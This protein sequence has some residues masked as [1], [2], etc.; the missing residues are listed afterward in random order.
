[1]K[2]TTTI[3]LAALTLSVFA[4]AACSTVKPDEALHVPVPQQ[5]RAAAAPEQMPAADGV[6][7]QLDRGA[8]PVP[9]WWKAY[10]SEELDA[11][12]EEGLAHSP[13][14]AAAQST[15]KSAHEA[16]RAQLGETLMPSVDLQGGAIREKALGLPVL[17]KE[18]FDYNV[19]DAQ[20]TA[21]YTFN[22]FGAQVLADRSAQRRYQEQ[23]YQLEETRRALA[24]NI[25]LATINAASM[26][27]QLAA[28][29]RLVDLAEERARQTKERFEAGSASRADML[30]DEQQAASLAATLPPM[31]AQLQT[32][33]HAQAILLGRTPDR[34]PQPLAMDALHLPQHVP[35]ALP[36]DLLHQRPDILA[37]EA[38]VRAS[39]DAAGAAKAELFPSLTLSAGY[40]RGG[41]DW[42]TFT[43][44]AGAIWSA[45]SMITQPLFHG[46][47]LRA[48]KREYEAAYE[49]S[50]SQYEQTVLTAFANV[51]D[52]LAALEE[53]A[54]ALAQSE[55]AQR[56]AQA[57]QEDSADRYHLGSVPY[58]GTLT[59]GERLQTAN[60]ELTRARALRLADTAN[61]FQAM[62]DAPRGSD[63]NFP[64]TLPTL[65]GS[66]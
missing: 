21:S 7:Q 50:V 55:R 35:V 58:W 62:G 51:A 20:A 31:R 5:Y 11:L 25:V 64:R 37:A 1:M 9:Q 61:L 33:R 4:L 40:G 32:I 53:D 26:Q 56:A 44:P 41:F 13:S 54:N 10:G 43:S 27:E 18:T 49:A 63:E 14:L 52:T 24:A 17:P 3:R 6:Q 66:E 15:L 16:L 28:T 59:A 38:A 46:G 65:I 23:S 30:A 45:G 60:I 22:F 2:T 8:R 34:A 36:T 42:S 39:A 48:R 47:A 29:Q 19:F 57:E 12:V